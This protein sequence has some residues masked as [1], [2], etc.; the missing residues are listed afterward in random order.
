LNVGQPTVSQVVIHQTTKAVV[1]QVCARTL[2]PCAA[3]R[4]WP[5]RAVATLTGLANRQASA[6]FFCDGPGVLSWMAASRMV[7]KAGF[8]AV[9][10]LRSCRFLL[11]HHPWNGALIGMTD[12]G[13]ARCSAWQCKLCVDGPLIVKYLPCGSQEDQASIIVI[14]GWHCLH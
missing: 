13:V 9:P 5:H 1:L 7:G 14:I 11:I 2:G 3:L 4:Q 8:G 10:P 12:D 6:T